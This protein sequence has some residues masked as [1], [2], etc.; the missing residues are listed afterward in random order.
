M[1]FG[2]AARRG[3]AYCCHNLC[4]V[5][6]NERPLRCAQHYNSQPTTGKILLV[7]NILVGRQKKAKPSTL[8]FV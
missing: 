6:P 3:C 2:K 5:Q 8:C 7:S 1:N 4:N